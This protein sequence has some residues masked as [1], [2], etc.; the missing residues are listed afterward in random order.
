MES[1]SR[2]ENNDVFFSPLKPIHSFY[3]DLLG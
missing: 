2:W 3:V 1:T